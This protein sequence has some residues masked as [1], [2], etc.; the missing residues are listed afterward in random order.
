LDQ[1]AVDR[2]GVL[3]DSWGIRPCHHWFVG[4]GLL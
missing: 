1:L 4:E 2:V 3:T